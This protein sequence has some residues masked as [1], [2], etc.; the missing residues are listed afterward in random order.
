MLFPFLSSTGTQVFYWKKGWT[1]PE[2]FTL[3]KT[4]NPCALTH[5][6]QTTP[7]SPDL[8]AARKQARFNHRM[9]KRKLK[10]ISK[11]RPSQVTCT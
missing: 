8:S 9:C 6:T 11:G 2:N 7:P 5:N 10:P 3:P 1:T 4:V